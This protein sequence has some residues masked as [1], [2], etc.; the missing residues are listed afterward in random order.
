MASNRRTVA[1][2]TP[3]RKAFSY[4]RFSTPEQLKGDSLRR[5]LQASEDYADRHNLVLDDSLQ[6]RDLGMSAFRGKNA[7]RGALS[8]FIEAVRLGKVPKGAV[9]IV[10]SL[11][12]IS[13]DEI[14]EALSLFISILNRG[15]E[16]ATIT[17][18][19]RYTKQSI[20][21]VA[22]ILEAIIYMARAHEESAMKSQRLRTA[23][24]NK[25]RNIASRKLTAICPAWLELND[26]R[27]KYVKIPKRVATVKRV[28]RLA[29]DGNGAN[30]IAKQF[31]ERGVAPIGRASCW[32][33][34]YIM[35]ILKNRAVLGEFQPHTSQ[36][37]PARKPLG[38]PIPN[39]YPPI[40]NETLWAKAQTALA[41]RVRER[42]PR[43]KKISNLFTG[44]LR[45]ARDGGPMTIV[46]KGAKSS[47]IQIVS[48]AAQRGQPGSTYASFRYGALE[49]AILR[50]TTELTPEDLSDTSDRQQAV[51]EIEVTEARLLDLGKR[52]EHCQRQLVSDGEFQTLV[53]VLRRLED[54]REVLLARRER[55]QQQLLIES[56]TTLRDSQQLIERLA[57]SRG[58]ELVNL[59]LR[60]RTRLKRIIHEIWVLVL[61]DGLKRKALVQMGLANGSHRKLLVGVERGGRSTWEEVT[62]EAVPESELGIDLREYRHGKA[63]PSGWET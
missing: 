52:I 23:W 58:E 62:P 48:A 28:F 47:G 21:D 9:L 34:S 30:S 27:S 17:P 45:D 5:Q 24:Q 41:Q 20:N 37:G 40:I 18:E 43:G 15:V 29:A 57:A 56:E 50:W 25:R 8:G 53:E 11:D 33:K 10:E 59:R 63:I 35:K 61:V 4:I 13:R 31:N 44:L 12:R 42:G 16:I 14:G 3:S 46:D 26:D 19:R 55:L 49:E 51:D 6:L 22:G 36:A 38:E 60:L 39:Y 1:S 7:E 2:H 32:H 54:E